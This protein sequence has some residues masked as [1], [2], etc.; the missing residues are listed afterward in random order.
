MPT[1]ALC[2]LTCFDNYV[3][4]CYYNDIFRTEGLPE[5]TKVFC[6][7]DRAIYSPITAKSHGISFNLEKTL[8]DDEGDD[9]SNKACEFTFVRK[10]K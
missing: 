2:A 10:K 1:T 4:K 3:D 5:L 8:A 9:G 7:L 6:A